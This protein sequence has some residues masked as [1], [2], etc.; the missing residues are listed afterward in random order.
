MINSVPRKSAELS[1][2]IEAQTKAFLEMG[3]KIN[4]VDMNNRTIKNPKAHDF[5]VSNRERKAPT[6]PRKVK[7]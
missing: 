5:V 4:L 2:E 3:G 1:A 6:D 7:A